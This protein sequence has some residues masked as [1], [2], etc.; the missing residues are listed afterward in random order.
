[1]LAG[2][3]FLVS[4]GLDYRYQHLDRDVRSRGLD[5]VCGADPPTLHLSLDPEFQNCFT[6]FI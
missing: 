4:V 2:V 1:M 5:L 3:D 6:S